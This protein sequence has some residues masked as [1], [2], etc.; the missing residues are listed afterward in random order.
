MRIG[1]LT[2]IAHNSFIFQDFW[3]ILIQDMLQ[4]FWMILIQDMRN[5]MQS[6]NLFYF[7]VSDHLYWQEKFRKWH[8]FSQM[9]HRLSTL[10]PFEYSY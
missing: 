9:R 1:T 4:D 10:P 7:C 2:L 6:K 3:M 5:D 8:N